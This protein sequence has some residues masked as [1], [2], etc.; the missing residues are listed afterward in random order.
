MQMHITCWI[1]ISLD[2]SATS[3]VSTLKARRHSA[4]AYIATLQVSIHP[5]GEHKLRAMAS[6]QA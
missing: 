6:A 1:C 4:A 3:A 2:A 5:I